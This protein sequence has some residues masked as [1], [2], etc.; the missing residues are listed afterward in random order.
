MAKDRGGGN[1]AFHEVTG[2]VLAPAGFAAAGVRAGI[3]RQGRDI[4]LIVSEVPA[5]AAAIFTTNRAQAAPVQV[6]RETAAGGRARAIVANSGNAN[7]CTGEGGLEDARRMAAI[8]AE[9]AGIDPGEVLV[10]STGVIGHRLPMEKIASGIAEA[11]RHLGRENAEAVAEAIMTTDTFAKSAAVAFE[12]G[13]RTVTVGGI[14]KGAGMICPQM[15]TMFCFVTTDLAISAPMLRSALRKAADQSFNCLTVDGDMSTNDT[16]FILAN[17]QAGNPAIE[18][19]GP[20]MESFQTALDDVCLK[21]A[22]MMARD[23][24]GATKLVVVEVEGAADNREARQAAMTIANSPLV[25]TALFGCDPNWGRVVAAAGRAGIAF[26]VEKTTVRFGPV[27]VM[28]KGTPLAFDA[29]AARAY[30]DKEEVALRV[31]MGLGAGRATVYTCDLTYDYI[32]VNAEY[33]T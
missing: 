7:A 1:S 2:G 5:T 32:K 29:E 4:A 8:T 22:R 25:K 6:S 14:A 13:G 15:A 31:E 18:A 20:E 10:A 17:G 24:E 23:G 11:A 16:M 27:T 26:E 12:V 3:K 28:E 19:E 30:L 21:L 9:Q 33:H